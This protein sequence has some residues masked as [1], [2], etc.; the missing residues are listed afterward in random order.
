MRHPL[1][2]VLAALLAGCA[3]IHPGEVGVKSTFGKL[4]D[5]ARGPGLAVYGPIGTR[6]IR[7]PTRTTN[8]EV[9][10]SL[11]SKEGLNVKARV[12]I[13]YRVD[14]DQ[15]PL[16]VERVGEDFEQ[17]LVLPVFRSAA[18]DV[19]ARYAAK[20]MH[21]GARA[22]I[23]EAVRQRMEEVLAKRGVVV[24]AVLLKSIQLPDG[25]YAAVE[26]KLSAEQQ[27]QRMEYVLE[28]ERQEAERRR[29]EAEGI[30]DAQ[31][32]LEEGLTPSVLAWRSLEAF[33][34]LSTSE[35]AKVIVT[36]GKAPLLIEPEV[37]D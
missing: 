11:P 12:S 35:N 24:E 13:L 14:P 16:L 4:A 7:V 27:A 2:P 29:I 10:L 15:A 34:T 32:I 23:E 1:L 36:D 20:D 37:P 31:R 18:A 5:E 3:T 28:R 8:V 21:S 22:G 26:D 33:E 19:S 30:R 6:Y 17:E 9:Q 25:L